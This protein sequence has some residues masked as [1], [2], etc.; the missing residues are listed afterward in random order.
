MNAPSTPIAHDGIYPRCVW[1]G[2]ENY[3]PAVIKYSKGLTD[4]AAV[5][6]CGKTLPNEYILKE[7]DNK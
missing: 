5:S 1:C 6:S 4:C 7:G 2:G 3:A